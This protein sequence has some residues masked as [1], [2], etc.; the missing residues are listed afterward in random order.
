M[1]LVFIDNIV[2]QKTVHLEG[3]DYKLRNLYLSKLALK[4]FLICKKSETLYHPQGP[5]DCLEDVPQ[6]NYQRIYARGR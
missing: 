4:C 1:S 6:E 2:V 5:F 3:K